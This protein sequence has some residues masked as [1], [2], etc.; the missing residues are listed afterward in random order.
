[1]D[2]VQYSFVNWEQVKGDTPDFIRRK[3]LTKGTHTITVSTSLMISMHGSAVCPSTHLVSTCTVFKF[4]FCSFFLHYLLSMVPHA[5]F[6]PTECKR[7]YLQLKSTT[8]LGRSSWKQAFFEL[9]DTTLHQFNNE[10]SSQ[11]D[12]MSSTY[13]QSQII[14]PGSLI[15]Y[16]R[17]P[18]H[19]MDVVDANEL[20]ERENRLSFLL[21]LATHTLCC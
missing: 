1:M 10:V 18:T 12:E 20:P 14:S 4:E 7:G 11:Q 3:H 8:V 5:L 15:R 17:L 9:H 16:P 21:L 19:S 6:T 2:I 13:F